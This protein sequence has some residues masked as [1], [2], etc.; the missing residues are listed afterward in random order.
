M[1]W[2]GEKSHAQS[3]RGNCCK[4]TDKKPQG[5]VW[6][7]GCEA[8]GEKEV[9]GSIEK[10]GEEE[11]ELEN[12]PQESACCLSSAQIPL[13][14]SRWGWGGR[15][16]TMATAHNSN[17]ST[18]SHVISVS[19]FFLNLAHSLIIWGLGQ[20]FCF[21]TDFIFEFLAPSGHSIPWE[22]LAWCGTFFPV[23]L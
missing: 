10:E 21:L 23:Q 15:A 7:R 16:G 22:S 18:L 5:Q 1:D 20:S 11:Q 2:L 3:S 14:L 8:A 4:T 12:A 13:Q 17:T 19:I 6:G 9:R